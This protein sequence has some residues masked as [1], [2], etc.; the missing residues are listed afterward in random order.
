[1]F[2]CITGGCFSEKVRGAHVSRIQ[3]STADGGKAGRRLEEG[4][5][6]SFRLTCILSS[7]LVPG[8][9]CAASKVG[10]GSGAAEGAELIVPLAPQK[11]DGVQKLEQ[12]M[13]MHQP[14]ISLTKPLPTTTIGE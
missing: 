9:C 13:V 11:P 12:L 3:L 7:S 1:M 10:C 4:V 2:G 6:T 14:A 8:S 5:G